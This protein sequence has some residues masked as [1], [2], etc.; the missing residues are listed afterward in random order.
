M[1]GRIERA[2][3]GRGPLA[4]ALLPAALLFAALTALHRALFRWG[5]LQSRR[6]AVPVVVVG[7]LVAGGAGKTPTVLAVVD[8]L[9]RRGHHPGIVSRGYGRSGG[10]VTEV[11]TDTAAVLAG[12]EPLLLR[13][14]SGAPVVVGNDRAAAAETLL[15]LHPE[16]DVVVSDDGLQHRRLARDVQV[17][18][19]DERGTGNGWPL[20]AGPLREPLPAQL[21]PRSLVVYNAARPTTTLPGFTARSA[22]AG[23][24]TLQDWW[25]GAA[26]SL[27]A[28]HALR[29]RSIVAAAGMARPQRFFDM[30]RAAGLA[31][32]ELA[33][34][35]HHD[36]AALPWPADTADV[37]VTEKDAVKLAPDR[38]QGARLWVATLDF[39]LGADF[40]AA[41][42]QLLA[43]P[44]SEGR[45]HGNPTA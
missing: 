18:V 1:A 22:L 9:R 36:F 5:W 38:M 27:P 33:L 41:L 2:W 13:R 10:A 3:A 31:P 35:D 45:D 23:V 4:V 29:G 11:Q 40:D 37:V 42:G 25:A 44:P 28:L 6:V 26:P 8:L 14:R 16:V 15:H 43:S 39:A 19:F 12:D 30:L 32:T 7:N 20:P 34:P 21:P 17:L 24:C